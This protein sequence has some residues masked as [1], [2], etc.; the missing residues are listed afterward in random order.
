[1]HQSSRSLGISDEPFAVVSAVPA[2]FGASNASLSR[3]VRASGFGDMRGQFPARDLA[4]YLRRHPHLLDDRV[5]YSE[6]KRTS[7]GWYLRPPNS[8][9]CITA[10]SPSR[11]QHYVDR[12]AACEAFIIAEQ[13]AMLDRDAAV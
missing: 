11:E 9:G 13:S 5:R 2:A 4:E 12:A 6:E 1:M 3:V 10:Y 7:D 8:V